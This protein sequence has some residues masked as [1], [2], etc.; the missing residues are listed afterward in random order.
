MG[1]RGR[2]ARIATRGA[3]AA[4]L[5]VALTGCP[6]PTPTPTPTPTRSGGYTVASMDALIAELATRT[7]QRLGEAE[8]FRIIVTQAAYPI[9]TLMRPG[10]TI[11]ID[12]RA[13][14]PTDGPPVAKAPSLFPAYALSRETAVDFGLDEAVLQGVAEAGASVSRSNAVRLNFADSAIA[15]LSDDDVFRITETAACSARL[16]QRAVWL[17][18]GYVLGRRTFSLDLAQKNQANVKLSKVASFDVKIADGSSGLAIS[19]AETVGF[20]QIVSELRPA[21][22]TPPVPLPTVAPTGGPS[23]DPAPTASNPV[24]PSVTVRAPAPPSRQPGRIYV[25]RDAADRSG[26]ADAIVTALGAADL[27]AV[28]PHVEAIA[29]DKVP[30]IAQIRY[31]N[32]GDAALV[33]TALGILQRFYPNA[34]T[35]RVRLPSPPGQLEVWLPRGGRTRANP[36]AARQEIVATKLLRTKD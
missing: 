25:Q 11:P 19:D 14:L 30:A 23:G 2:H 36:L 31:F 32:A 1:R 28:E 33:A 15:A 13:C 5:A 21:S 27:P 20:L 10:S 9:G 8:D 7:Q 12:Y 4:A 22:T 18:R 6:G 35:I 24:V 26:K 34:T 3:S 29:G 16:K 17:V